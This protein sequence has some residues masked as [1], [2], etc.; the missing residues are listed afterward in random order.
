MQRLNLYRLLI[1]PFFF[2]TSLL[3]QNM[4]EQFSLEQLMALMAKHKEIH[5]TFV[6]KKYIGGVKMPIESSGE[7]KFIAPTTMIRN[8]LQPKPEIFQL[9]DDTITLERKGKTHSL[10]VEDYP[11]LA[12]YFEGMRTLLSGNVDGM[13]SL[14]KVDFAGTPAE[15]EL[16]L[17]PLEKGMTLK[18]LRLNGSQDYVQSVEVQM[19]DGDYSI[20]QI[21]RQDGVQ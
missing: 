13:T 17:H 16:V 21:S 5:A 7:L 14:Y 9:A 4:T 3:A 2:S 19:E 6:E 10:Q 18:A 8:T 20:M 11:E 12:I 1:L 15:W